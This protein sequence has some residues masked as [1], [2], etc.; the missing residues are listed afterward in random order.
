M[1]SNKEIVGRWEEDYQELLAKMNQL[2]TEKEKLP[3]VG[4]QEELEKSAVE[5]TDAPL[6]P[7][8]S[9]EP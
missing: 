2:T 8:T 3:T 4:E 9:E 5:N 1:M 6:E 7:V